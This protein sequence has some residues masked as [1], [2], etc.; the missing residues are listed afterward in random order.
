MVTEPMAD[1]GALF[2]IYRT[3]L[4]F[5]SIRA[6]T[7][8][9]VPDAL[10]A[11]PRTVSRLAAEVGADEDA[12]RRVLRLLAAHGIVS[13]DDG[14]DRV[15]LTGTGQLL[16]RAHPMSLSATFSTL[17]IGDV[18]HA[19]PEVIRTGRP[20]VPSVLGEG[21]WEYLAA[22]PEQQVVFSEA[23]AEQAQLLSLPCVDLVDWPEQGTVADIAGGVGA[24]LAAVLDAA[25]GLRG[26]LV[27]QAAT[28]D[29]AR[30]HLERAGVADRC[31]LRPGDLFEPPPAADLYLLSRV[32]HDW[33]DPHAERILRAVATAARPHSRLRLFEDLLP[34]DRPPAPVQCWSDVVMMSLYDG[35]RERTLA[36]FGA[37][38]ERGGWHMV[39]AVEGPPGMNIVEARLGSADGGGR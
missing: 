2:D 4:A 34:H 12:L 39:R 37:L 7:R 16:S 1:I 22:R 8:L 25:P 35:A 13:L 29:R 6:V 14:T 33:D 15:A 20:A 31:T 5:H 19:L 30:E 23:M 36:E 27:D 21:F 26:V 9:G 24:L 18:A 17:G 28:L 11:G 3:G 38:L 10:A 32:L